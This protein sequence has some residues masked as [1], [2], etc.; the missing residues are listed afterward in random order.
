VRNDRNYWEQI[1]VYVSERTD[2]RFT[3]GIC[4]DCRAKVRP[5]AAGTA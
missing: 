3:H 1:E 4:P 5:R 2:A